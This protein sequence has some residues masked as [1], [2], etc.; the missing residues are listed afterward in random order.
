[1]KDRARSH[2]QVQADMASLLQTGRDGKEWTRAQLSKVSGV[3]ADV[4]MKIELQQ[5]LPSVATLLRL[6]DAL[7]T[8]VAYFFRKG[9]G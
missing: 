7:G 4:I 1:M 5:R 6:A 8:D 2:E 3:H 9:S